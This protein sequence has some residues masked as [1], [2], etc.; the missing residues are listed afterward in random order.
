[1]FCGFQESIYM[2]Y[3]V[4][5]DLMME[6]LADMGLQERMLRTICS[7]YWKPTLT[8]KIGNSLGQP[9]EST[10]GVK[11]GDP[12]SPVVSSL[13]GLRSGLLRNS[14]VLKWTWGEASSAATV[15]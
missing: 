11:Q 13:I 3:M 12:L 14:Q 10:R 2:I 15:R 8:V 4:Q 5:W 1:L 9:F 6:C 7:M